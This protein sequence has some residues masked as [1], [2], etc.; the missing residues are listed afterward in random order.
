VESMPQEEMIPV[1]TTLF[2]APKIFKETCEI[3]W[4]QTAKR[5]YDF[6]RGLSPYPAAWTT[7]TDDMGNETSL[8]VY[9]TG[10]PEPFTSTDKPA[11]GSLLADRKTLRVACADGWLQILSLQQSGKKRMDTDAFLRGYVLSDT[12]RCH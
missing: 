6:V 10:E 3:N 9:A 5:V 7:L 12:A 2:G 1:G 8:K 11:P 4:R